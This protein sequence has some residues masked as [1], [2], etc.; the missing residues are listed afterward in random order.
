MKALKIIGLIVLTFLLV[1][2]LS[3]FGV[4]FNIDRTALN[5]GFLPGQLDRLPV[6][7]L[8][9]ETLASSDSGLSINMNDTVVRVVYTL[10]PQIKKQIRAANSQVYAYLLGRQQDIDLRQ[11]LKDTLLNQ[12]FVASVLNEA[13]VFSLIRRNL[14]DELAA[15]IPPGQ[16]QLVVYLD[17]AM[18]SLDPWLKEQVNTA[19][20][21]VI[22]YLLGDT[23]TLSISIPL[24]QMKP[25][26]KASLREAFL[27][28]PPPELAGATREQQETVF[29]QYYQEFAAQIPS[30]AGIDPSSLG[31]E[32]SSSWAQSFEDA[33]SALADSR[34]FISYF[35]TGFLFLILF[36]LLLITGIVLIYRDVKSASREL[37]IIFLSYGILEYL[38]I[39]I[40]KYSFNAGLKMAEMPAT[41]R[42][43][44]PGFY[45]ASFRP[46][47]FFSIVMA[48]LGLALIVL[49]VLYRRRPLQAAP[50]A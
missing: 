3:V 24:E 38:V 12:A 2:S 14:R 35:R 37:G 18:P 25:A 9:E 46:L 17:Q 32:T 49:S 48:I 40:G 15:I 28:S 27:D 16:Q 11:V 6:A 31:I 44:L 4:G 21:P 13:D 45:T 7:A 30:T 26:L 33:E 20:G 19:A 23:A 43:W 5:P 47:E 34:L 1:I 39:I 8:L 50:P 41:L 29:D 42:A 22:D 10:E 36:I